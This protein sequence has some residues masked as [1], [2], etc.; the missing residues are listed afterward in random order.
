MAEAENIS[1]G[2]GKRIFP[3]IP[4]C[5]PFS[6]D[7]STKFSSWWLLASTSSISTPLCPNSKK[8]QS[9]SDKLSCLD[10]PARSRQFLHRDTRRVYMSRTLFVRHCGGCLISTLSVDLLAQQEN[11]KSLTPMPA[12]LIP[13]ACFPLSMWAERLGVCAWEKRWL[14]AVAVCRALLSIRCMNKSCWLLSPRPADHSVCLHMQYALLSNFLSIKDL[15]LVFAN[16]DLTRSLN[17]RVIF[18]PIT[19]LVL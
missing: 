7:T 15:I 5:T 4:A 11:I 14:V 3:A 18:W 16:V 9:F 12:A 2:T 6:E 10:R 17:L 13:D 19:S 8:K 1:R